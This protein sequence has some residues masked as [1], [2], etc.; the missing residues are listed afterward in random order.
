[1]LAKTTSATFL[2]FGAVSSAFRG[3]QGFIKKEYTLS[4]D[5]IYR[6]YSYNEPVY[7]EPMEG[8]AM[9]RITRNPEIEEI[10]NFA[11]HRDIRINKG[12]W[13]A[14]APMSSYTIYNLYIPENAERQ[15]LKLDKPILYNHITPTLRINEIIAYYYVVKRPGYVFPG[16]VHNYFEL[17]Y[18]DHGSLLTHV[19][20][21]D[22]EISS[23]Q[24]MMYGPGQFHNQQ[25]TSSEACSYMTV[26]FQA[27][28]INRDKVLNRVFT[29]N[30]EMVNDL[31]TFVKA[32]D[33]TGEY[34]NDAMIISLQYIL[35]EMLVSNQE[36]Y[37]PK[38]ISPINQHFE[39]NLM[40]EII[41]YINHHLYE[42]LPIE[43][44]CAK[45]SISRSTLQNLFK[46]NLQIPPKQYIN[47][48]K[49]SHSR[50]MI[51][52]GDHTIS[53]I[54]SMLGFTPIHY[55]SRRF[56]SYYGITPSEYARKIYPESEE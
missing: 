34:H 10:E 54:A 56:T 9:L 36:E 53:E 42:P 47:N 52:K 6:L 41:D 12:N 18:V 23:G 38:P 2:K 37:Q 7:V 33:D 49:L 30:R 26:I 32:T 27:D 4:D 51:R 31:N 43:Q 35:I 22:Y 16:E 17:T 3:Q 5:T 19:N 45:F 48:A 20:G 14:L 29:C 24:V 11:L 39:D 40:E 55:F 1:M 21:V 28:G 25:V 13:F 46:N 44:I 50:A 15:V 8:M